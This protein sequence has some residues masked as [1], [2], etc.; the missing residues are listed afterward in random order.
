MPG[1]TTTTCSAASR[2]FCRPSLSLSCSRRVTRPRHCRLF[3]HTLAFHVCLFVCLFAAFC[4]HHLGHNLFSAPMSLFTRFGSQHN[5]TNNCHLTHVERLVLTHITTLSCRRCA[6]LAKALR[7]ARPACLRARHI[8]RHQ[9]RRAHRLVQPEG[10]CVHVFVFV[11][12]C[13]IV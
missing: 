11:H 1:G 2:R 6:G 8:Q 5:T 9:P 10:R 12:V 4:F 13:V 3:L 7:G